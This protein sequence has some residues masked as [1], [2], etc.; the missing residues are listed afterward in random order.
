MKFEDKEVNI[1]LGTVLTGVRNYRGLTKE[2]AAEL[3]GLSTSSLLNWERGNVSLSMYNFFRL[4][5]A[6]KIKPTKMLSLI[7]FEL[8]RRKDDDSKTN[9]D[10]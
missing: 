9:E 10:A 2:R 4:C 6:F 1:A 3:H 5:D 8:Q 7:E